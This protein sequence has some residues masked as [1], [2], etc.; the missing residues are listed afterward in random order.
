MNFENFLE[1]VKYRRSIR[2]FKP[3]PIPEDNIMKILDAAH[4]AMSGAN[5]QPWEFIVVKDPEI[6][7]K[8][9]EAYLTHWERVWHLEQQRVPEYR[10]PTYNIPKEE[11]DKAKARIG[12]RDAPVYLVIL[13]DPRKQYGSVMIARM[14]LNGTLFRSMGHLSM[15]IQLAAA[16]LGLGSQRVD[17]SIQA[18]FREIL[19]YTEPLELECIV[20]VGY[21]SA[22]PGPPPRLP[23]EELVHF[24][25]YDMNKFLRDEDF[26]KYMRRIFE[27]RTRA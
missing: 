16:S 8:L 21:R 25:Q 7:R 26:E 12:W 4:Y 27:L 5:C 20:P 6:K 24:D 15:L 23:L 9:F 1:V 10:H 11:K 22:E 13:Y 17:V 3:D 18:P 2:S 19:G 14:L